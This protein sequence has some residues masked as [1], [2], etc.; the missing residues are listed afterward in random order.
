MNDIPTADESKQYSEAK[1]Y[2]IE[3]AATKSDAK[4]AAAMR[5]REDI[6]TWRIKDLQ[7]FARVHPKGFE[8]AIVADIAQ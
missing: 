8:V 2:V 3:D 5:Y 7:S 4:E 1:T 6:E